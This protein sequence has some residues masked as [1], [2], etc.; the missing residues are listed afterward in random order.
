[1]IS[2]PKDRVLTWSVLALMLSLIEYS[3]G[4]FFVEGSPLGKYLE[5]KALTQMVG[6][7]TMEARMAS[8]LFLEANSYPLILM[9]RFS[10][11]WV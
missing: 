7:A 2:Q 5:K 10:G 6:D 1:M 8:H 9:V 3:Q 11:Q 4:V